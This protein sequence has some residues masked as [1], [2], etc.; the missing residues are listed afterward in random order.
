MREKIEEKDVEE[1][2]RADTAA[3]QAATH[4]EVRNKALDEA[5]RVMDAEMRS[6]RLGYYDIRQVSK[7]IRA[8]KEVQ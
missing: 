7:A 8:L 6:L 2:W 5:M 4:A 3:R 1:A